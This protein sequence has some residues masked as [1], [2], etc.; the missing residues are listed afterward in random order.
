MTRQ[1]WQLLAVMI[2]DVR[3]RDESG[4]VFTVTGATVDGK[5]C[6]SRVDAKTDHAWEV[7]DLDGLEVQ[8]RNGNWVR[9]VDD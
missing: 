4:R 6:L 9:I 1:F 7:T 8:D 5:L 3:I 2:R